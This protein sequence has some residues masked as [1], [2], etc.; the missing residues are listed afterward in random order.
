MKSVLKSR[1]ISLKTSKIAPTREMCLT[2]QHPNFD[3][4]VGTV[5]QQCLGCSQHPIPHSKAKSLNY[6]LVWLACDFCERM[7]S[8]DQLSTPYFHIFVG[9]K[10]WTLHS[11]QYCSYIIFVAPYVVYCLVCKSA[12]QIMQMKYSWD[13]KQFPQNSIT[14]KRT[15]FEPHRS[16]TQACYHSHQIQ[17]KKLYRNAK[18]HLPNTANKKICRIRVLIP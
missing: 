4:V 13:R 6:C 17:R 5:S 10:S 16:A 11:Q 2:Y 8:S 15:V 9:T 14:E 3:K 1:K 7:Y 12:L 18:N